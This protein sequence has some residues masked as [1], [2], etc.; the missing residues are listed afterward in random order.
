MC[1]ITQ[2]IKMIQKEKE[3]SEINDLKGQDKVTVTTA[4]IDSDESWIRAKEV[5]I[6]LE[7]RPCLGHAVDDGTEETAWVHVKESASQHFAHVAEAKEKNSKMEIPPEFMEFRT[8]FEKKSS[9]RLPN[10]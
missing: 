10:H 7:E 2:I 9:E 4:L 3:L 1:Q 5:A 8:V 6:F